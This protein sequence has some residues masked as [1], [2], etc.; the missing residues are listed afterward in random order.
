MIMSGVLNG[1]KYL[2]LNSSAKHRLGGGVEGS[3]CGPMRKK[4]QIKNPNNVLCYTL[5][6]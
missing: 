5:Q 2:P 4:I 3:G 6:G 1:K